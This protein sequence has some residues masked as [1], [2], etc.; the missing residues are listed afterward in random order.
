MDALAGLRRQ[1]S[2]LTSLQS[3]VRALRLLSA[4]NLKM[5]A[6]VESAQQGCLDQLESAVALLLQRGGQLPPSQGAPRRLILGSDHGLCGGFH[7]GLVSYCLEHP[8][9]TPL[10][11]V[12]RRLGQALEEKGV[13][14]AR[15]LSAPSSEA[16]LQALVEELD[17]DLRVRVEVILWSQGRVGQATLWPPSPQESG[18]LLKKPWPGRCRPLL[19]GEPDRLVMPVLQQWLAWRCQQLCLTSL[20]SENQARL[21][22]MQAA[23]KNL[24]SIRE[25]LQDRSRQLHQNVVTEELLDVVSGFEILNAGV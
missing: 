4:V 7:Q 5:L 21:N 23:E 24:A 9:E 25:S 2:T 11:C 17:L 10:G 6:K 20:V 12:G 22:V 1:L 13:P 15:I 16:G 14:L 3:L 8:E 19:W 18:K